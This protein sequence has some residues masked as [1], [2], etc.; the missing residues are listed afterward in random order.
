MILWRNI[1]SSICL[2]YCCVPLF[3]QEIDYSKC[4]CDSIAR[5][6]TTK[7]SNPESYSSDA[8]NDT[9]I[10]SFIGRFEIEIEIGKINWFWGSK[11]EISY[12][13]KK[14][15]YRN[16]SDS[17]VVKYSVDNIVQAQSAT[18]KYRF[19]EK[20]LAYYYNDEHIIDPEKKGRG[21]RF[22]NF[23]SDS[24]IYKGNKIAYFVLSHYPFAKEV[25]DEFKFNL[26]HE[27]YINKSNEDSIIYRYYL[28]EE[29]FYHGLT[30]NKIK[31]IERNYKP[32]LFAKYGP[33]GTGKMLNGNYLAFDYKG[34]IFMEINYSNGMKHGKFYYKPPVWTLV[35]GN[36]DKGQY[37]NGKKAGKWVY[38]R[39]SA[40]SR[41]PKKYKIKYDE[42]GKPKTQKFVKN[43]RQA[44]KRME[45][46]ESGDIYELEPLYFNLYDHF[47]GSGY[48]FENKE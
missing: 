38:K 1:L 30:K 37:L 2:V 20:Y 25:K 34:K 36:S 32:I 39:V 11:S 43:D 45:L 12:G 13:L 16:E 27:R 3:A 15:I 29:L 7:L 31:K 14:C 17:I 4:S 40:F 21:I 47:L 18:G 10:K 5:F 35:H 22:I 46:N 44:I 8:L 19:G 24:L 33:L 41:F 42:N 23:A 26:I 6:F 28:P 9:T 48:P